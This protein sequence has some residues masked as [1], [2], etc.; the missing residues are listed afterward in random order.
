MWVVWIYVDVGRSWA[1]EK[2]ESISLMRD[3][4][5]AISG[6][7]WRNGLCAQS[8]TPPLEV[9]GTG[10]HEA[11]GI[12]ELGYGC[13]KAEK[14]QSIVPRNRHRIATHR[15]IAPWLSRDPGFFSLQ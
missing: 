4:Q 11:L 9:I 1:Y 6:R 3:G 14:Q 7:M 2:T 12:I 10:S 15:K 13:R 5:H 8:H